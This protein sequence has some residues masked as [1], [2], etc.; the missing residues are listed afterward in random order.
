MAFLLPIVCCML[1]CSAALADTGCGNTWQDSLD[2]VH[3]R[4]KHTVSY[5]T[6]CEKR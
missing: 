6:I 1:A 4:G 2:N 5:N 3:Q